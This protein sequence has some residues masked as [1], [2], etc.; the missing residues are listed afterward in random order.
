MHKLFGQLLVKEVLNGD[1]GGGF[2]GVQITSGF[3]QIWR[4]E[5]ITSEIELY[6]CALAGLIMSGLMIF[7]WLVPLS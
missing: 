1:V 2:Q 6:W 4:A 7:C 5:G 3:F